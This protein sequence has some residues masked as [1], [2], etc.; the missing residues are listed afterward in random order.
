[1]K[2][3]RRKFL[4]QATGA[5]ALTGIAGCSGTDKKTS[6]V[7]PSTE[8]EE[9][10]GGIS[11]SSFYKGIR[12]DGEFLTVYVS[13]SLDV[14]EKTKSEVKA[15]SL[16][17]IA[18]GDYEAE[19]TPVWGLQEYEFKVGE[20]DHLLVATGDSTTGGD[21]P[22]SYELETQLKFTIENNQVYTRGVY[23]TNK[24]EGDL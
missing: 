1:M 8:D 19:R 15:N 6:A 20:G 17:L 18:D 9:S 3:T 2:N 24:M 5:A 23:F 22:D 16:V 14:A 13:K 21:F 10:S 7:T 11:G 4:K 12:Y